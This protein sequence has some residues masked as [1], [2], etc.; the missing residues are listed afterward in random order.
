M[1]LSVRINLE[2]SSLIADVEEVLKF[3]VDANR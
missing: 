3:D 2:N 1:P